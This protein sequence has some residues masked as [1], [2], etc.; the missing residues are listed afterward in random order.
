MLMRKFNINTL[1]LSIFLI[2]NLKVYAQ[3]KQD[4]TKILELKAVEI[5]EQQF[6]FNI[7]SGIRVMR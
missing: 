5:S 7:Q 6:K 2:L 3:I 1:T 4:S